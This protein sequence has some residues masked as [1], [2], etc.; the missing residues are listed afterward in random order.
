MK[1]YDVIIV[2]AGPAGLHCAET[3]KFSGLSVLLLEKNGVLGQ[4][5]CAGGITGKDIDL[6]HLP[7]KLFEHKVTSTKLSSIFNQS[8]T[9]ARQPF[10]YTINRK[11]LANWQWERLKYSN[12]EMVVSA[13]VT[14]VK[15]NKVIVNGTSEYRF[16]N[17]VGADGYASIVRRYLGLPVKARLI[18]I[19]YQV[20]L[21]GSPP[22]F[23]LYLHNHY[24][25]SWYGWIFPHR[26]T[27]AVG[28]V[29]DPR[30]VSSQKL[31]RKF[32]QWL[33]KNNF[34][35]TGAEYESQPI[36]CDHRGWEFGNIFLAG[37]AGGFASWLTGE[38]IYQCLVS[39]KAVAQRILDKNHH[40]EELDK[41]IRYNRIQ[42]KITK[43]LIYS[44]PFRFV[45]HELLI[46]AMKS[47][48]VKKRI[49]GAMT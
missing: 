37:E 21:N 8:A 13:Q 5:V 32:H 10:V 31:K 43:V 7:E 42:R 48:F 3:L 6:L 16:H 47:S 26:E 17:L 23:E 4:K 18:G 41:V 27:L 24:F 39:G 2:G 14:E 1:T 45:L 38:G 19:Q 28:C 20:P 35:L 36:G 11:E 34:D 9:D 40:S 46:L 33:K 15:R 44:G 22:R 49:N 12:I 30:Y 29:A 25:H